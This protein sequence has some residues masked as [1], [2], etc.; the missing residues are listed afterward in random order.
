[1]NKEWKTNAKA[2]LSKIWRAVSRNLGW[3]IV[4]VL[5]AIMLWSYVIS[6]DSSITRIKSISGV[7][8]AISGQSVLQSRDLA[9][10]MDSVDDL[11]DVRVRVEVPQSAY[12]RVS[13]D[14]VNVELDLSRVRQAGRQQVELVGTTTYGEVVQIIPSSLEV[15]IESR[16]ART[17]PVNVTLSGADE[18]SYYYT[19]N[20]RNPAQLTISGASSVVQR[21]TQAQ[22]VV[23][24]SGMTASAAR[25]V[26]VPY[27]LL[28]SEGEQI[29]QMLTRSTTSV[30]V[31]LSISPIAQLPVNASVETATTGT[32]ENG[33]RV[34]RVEVQPETITVAGDATLLSGLDQLTFAQ[35]DVS[36]RRQSFSTVASV[37]VLDDMKYISSKQVTVT[38]YIEEIEQVSRFDDVRV[39]VSGLT[40]GMKAELSQSVVQVKATGAYTK[41]NQLDGGQLLASVDA[42][43]LSE[44][45][46]DLPVAVSAD[47]F[48]DVAFEAEPQVIRV[49]IRAAE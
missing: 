9:V 41:M 29:T 39:T 12:A 28:D 27:I 34:T 37:N 3:K 21:I 38:V 25:S 20:S 35:V 47:N 16:D 31:G 26:A 18:D 36:G 1:M 7:D 40:E 19:V 4:S 8:V 32:P 45:I 46:Y 17:V 10:L 30:T 22:A 11:P 15:N 44:G 14:T 13:A 23:D 49:T 2:A 6:A 42:S 5:F 33:Y 48:P 43:G 24:V